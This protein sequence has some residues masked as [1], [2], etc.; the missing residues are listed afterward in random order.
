MLTRLSQSLDRR[1]SATRQRSNPN[2]KRLVAEPSLRVS[3]EIK[4]QRI[5]AKSR[6]RRK[7]NNLMNS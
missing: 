5:A 7:K 6:K 4:L 3:P 2:A 1:E